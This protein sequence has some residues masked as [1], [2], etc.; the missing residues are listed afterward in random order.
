MAYCRN[1]G[2]ELLDGDKFCQK[3]GCSTGNSNNQRQQ[4]F[5]GKIYKCPNC[6][7][8][9]KSFEINCPTC[10]C[11]LRDVKASNSVKEFALKLEEIESKREHEKSHGLFADS[12]ARQTI[13]KTDEQK[14]SLIK[15]YSIPNSRE[16]MLEFMILATSSMNMGVYDSYKK[17]HMTKSEVELNSAW[18]SKV[19]Q[20]YEKA[21]RSYFADKEFAE[22]QNLYNKC[23]SEIKK[24]K[25][26]GAIKWMLLL[27]WIPILLVFEFAFLFPYQT[28]KENQRLENIV[29]EVQTALENQEYKHAL[30]IADSISYRLGVNDEEKRKWEIQREY[31]IDKVLNEAAENGVYLDYAPN[32]NTNNAEGSVDEVNHNITN[33]TNGEETTN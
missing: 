33:E 2:A 24:S 1:C 21:K 11:E 25:K 18:F 20:V 15:S 3:C 10:G 17:G 6:G 29:I 8:V 12:I 9:L 13:S 7:E 5:V 4:G 19:Q 22:I 16:D 23:C 27:G 28:A 32:D 31:W 26:N 30:R 14:I